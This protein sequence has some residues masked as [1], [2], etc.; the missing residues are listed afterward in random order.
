[1]SVL[2]NDA[3]LR[4]VADVFLRLPNQEVLFH[5]HHMS[6]GDASKHVECMYRGGTSGLLEATG[7]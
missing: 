4:R 3:A 6:S 2:E 1:M 7:V 5:A